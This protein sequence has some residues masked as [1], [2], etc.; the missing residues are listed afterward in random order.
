[1]GMSVSSGCAAQ[2]SSRI[3][4]SSC[5]RPSANKGM[6][7]RPRRVTILSTVLV[8]SVLPLLVDARAVHALRDQDVGADGGNLRGHEVPVLLA[9]EVP[10]V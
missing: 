3:S 5:A 4:S 8:L 6:R 9:A 1:M 2:Y 10:G 7:Q